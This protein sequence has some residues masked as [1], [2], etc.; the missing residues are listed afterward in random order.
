M[1][2]YI[3]KK[4]VFT[5]EYGKS[6]QK[7]ISQPI[8]GLNKAKNEL[9]KLWLGLYNADLSD[10][11]H[12]PIKSSRKKFKDYDRFFIVKIPFTDNSIHYSIELYN[13]YKHLND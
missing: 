2:K 5:S 9:H 6:S 10:L 13:E 8:D 7:I 12:M 3:L 4:S 1:A 11:A